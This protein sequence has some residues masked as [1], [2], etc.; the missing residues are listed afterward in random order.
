MNLIKK[1]IEN[2]DIKLK[3]IPLDGSYELTKEDIEQM[4]ID[5]EIWNSF[6]DKNGNVKNEKGE[7]C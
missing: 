5:S 6:F 4:D 3:I 7:E 1:A 2:K